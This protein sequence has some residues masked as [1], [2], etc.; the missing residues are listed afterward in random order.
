MKLLTRNV[1]TL[2]PAVLAFATLASA[3][4]AAPNA[5]FGFVPIGTISLSPG[6]DLLTATSITLPGDL[7]VNTLPA[8]AFGLPN[9]FVGVFLAGDTVTQSPL[10][11][12]LTGPSTPLPDLLEFSTAIANRFTFSAATETLSFSPSTR[13]VA[14]YFLGTFHDTASVFADAPASLTLSFDQSAAN[15]AIDGSGTFSVPPGTPPGLPEPA[16]MI[17]TASALI[18]AGLLGRK[19]VVR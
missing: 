17:L 4:P 9:D 19:R 6:N 12:S 3:S 15:T 11:L 7:M 14:L 1:L 10:T 13:S 5:T 18:G 8:L 2:I 16:T